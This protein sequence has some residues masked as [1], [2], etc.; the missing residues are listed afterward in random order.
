MDVATRWSMAFTIS[1]R[2]GSAGGYE[3]GIS[4]ECGPSTTP[5]GSGGGSYNAGTNQ[6][7]GSGVNA[8]HGIVVITLDS[9]A[10]SWVSA[11]ENSGTVPVGESHPV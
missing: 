2:G 3:G 10:I 4:P 7:N 11:S 8:G 5:G 9:P 1:G 6:D